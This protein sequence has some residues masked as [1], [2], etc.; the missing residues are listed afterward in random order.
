MGRREPG[1]R[2][3]LR[4][5]LL[6]GFGFGGFGFGERFCYRA[7]RDCGGWLT[8][9]RS[10]LHDYGF[11]HISLLAIGGTLL[12]CGG[13]TGGLFRGRLDFCLFLCGFPLDGQDCLIDDCT[14]A[15][16]E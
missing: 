15:C 13:L 3:S 1:L 6:T 2:Y 8:W 12:L 14:A 10:G 5:L 7:L 4:G 16:I 9:S 11:L